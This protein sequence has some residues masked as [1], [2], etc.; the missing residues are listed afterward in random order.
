MP[1]TGRTDQLMR[2]RGYITVNHACALTGMS[3]QGFR[4]WL[5]GDPPKVQSVRVGIRL[6][7]SLA[8]LRE[9]LGDD[10]SKLFGIPEPPKSK[11]KTPPA[12]H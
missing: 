7:V 10:A 3:V 5:R 8:S 11:T 9:H 4:L 1:R 12:E 2:A 6:F